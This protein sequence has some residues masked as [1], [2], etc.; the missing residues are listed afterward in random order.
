MDIRDRALL[1]LEAVQK[2]SRGVHAPRYNPEEARYVAF[3]SNVNQL[4]DRIPE[5]R[6]FLEQYF[7]G[8]LPAVLTAA[9]KHE[10]LDRVACQTEREWLREIMQ[11]RHGLL[12]HSPM[13]FPLNRKLFSRVPSAAPSLDLGIGSGQNSRFSLQGHS[14]DVGADVML[15]N[16]LKARSIQSHGQYAALDMAALPFIESSFARVYALNCIYHAQD[17]RH[18]VVEEIARVLSP[19]GVLALTDVSPYLNDYKPLASF[20][21]A[22]GFNELKADFSRYFLSGYGAD[23]SPGTEEWYHSELPRLGFE[24]VHVQYLVSPRLSEISYLFYDWQALFNF[25]AHTSMVSLGEKHAY[26]ATYW[27]MLSSVV[28]PLLKKDE[29][30]CRNE[31]QGGYIF[32]TATKRQSS[33]TTG[34]TFRGEYCCPQC[35]TPL[36]KSMECTTCRRS[37]P[38]VEG[39]PLLTTFY[40][41]ATDSSQ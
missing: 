18:K 36:S 2:D 40:A 11:F 25:D 26:W 29:E 30:I 35:K 20:M 14:R 32:V 24:N 13:L 23:S 7:S 16:L 8:F 3:K 38:V 15:S 37:Y 33:G 34:H 10:G 1:D 5:K 39:I 22:L 17:G 4:L 28:A 9:A 41:T 12:A 31:K 21:G 19:G 6:E 27:E